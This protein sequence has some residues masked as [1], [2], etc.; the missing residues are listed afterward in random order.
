VSFFHPLPTEEQIFEEFTPVDTPCPA[1]GAS[2]VKR[3]KVL[4]SQGW[5]MVERCRACFHYVSEE[6]TDHSYVPLTRG[7]P[8]SSAG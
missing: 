6:P 1:C 4:R 8:T 7:W 2:E 3:Y 5:R